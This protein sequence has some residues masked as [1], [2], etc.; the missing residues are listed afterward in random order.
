MQATLDGLTSAGF[1]VAVY[2][3]D[4]PRKHLRKKK[5]R[6]LAQIVTPASPIYVTSSFDAEYD[7]QRLIPRYVA[8]RVSGK[9]F[10]IAC[11]DVDA[12][13]VDCA[14]DLTFDSANAVLQSYAV[15]KPAFFV[16]DFRKKSTRGTV[17][18]LLFSDCDEDDLRRLEIR[19]DETLARAL[20]RSVG[21]DLMKADDFAL[22]TREKD[23]DRRPLMLASSAREIG[24][25]TR[26]DLFDEVPPLM[27]VPKSSFDPPRL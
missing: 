16:D 7:F 19:S 21:R 22:D 4:D 3:E 25:S 17:Q 9:S 5:T 11:L 12:R 13:L 23:L 27:P 10:E 2:E 6:S 8:V 20:A 26:G 1:E 24:L 18:R 14:R 15:T